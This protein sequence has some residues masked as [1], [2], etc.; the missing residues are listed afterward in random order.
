[1]PEPTNKWFNPK[2]STVQ[3][4]EPSRPIKELQLDERFDKLES[5][6][7]HPFKSIENIEKHIENEQALIERLVQ[8]NLIRRS[9]QDTP[10][11]IGLNVSYQ[12]EYHRHLYV[13]LYSN[14]GFTLQVSTGATQ[15][16]P[17]NYWT[18]VSYP[19]GSYFTVSGGSDTAQQVCWVR[20]CD[21]PM[22]MAT[23]Q[24]AIPGSVNVNLSTTN[25]SSNNIP[26]AN[27]L[28]FG[29]GIFNPNTGQVDRVT[30]ITP[31]VSD[32]LTLGTAKAALLSW[33]GS[34][35]AWISERV[36][37]VFKEIKNTAVTAGTPVSVWTPAAGKSFHVLG[38][39]L[40]LS[41]AGEILLED[42]TGVEFWRTP[43][44]LAGTPFSSPVLKRGYISNAANNAMFIDVSA[45]GNVSGVVYGVEE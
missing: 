24:V 12:L 10:I 30:S 8:D 13:Y 20:A 6:L 15:V 44:L 35:N 1:M 34:A 25:Y 17:A 29:Q 40:S 22:E 26:A 45:S 2:G 4:T 5:A 21:V 37:T 9:F 33:G 16:I 7:V 42:T 19:R 27:V 28:E 18:N 23:Q 3:Q 11:S 32:G 41:V 31:T 38:Y 39:W 14:T 43:A 36:P